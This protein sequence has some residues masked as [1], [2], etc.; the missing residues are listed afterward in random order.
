MEKIKIIPIDHPLILALP[1]GNARDS[2][3]RYVT[4]GPVHMMNRCILKTYA[5]N[6]P[7]HKAAV[8]ALRNAVFP[9]AA[10]RRREIRRQKKLSSADTTAPPE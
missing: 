3:V 9:E 7:K 10:R 5:D 8:G 1:E 4:E 6:G 2:V